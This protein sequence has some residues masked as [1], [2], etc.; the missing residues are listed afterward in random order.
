MGNFLRRNMGSDS[1]SEEWSDEKDFSG[2]EDDSSDGEESSD[3]S[4]D[5]DTFVRGYRQ[6]KNSGKSKAFHWS[7]RGP[8][9]PEHWGELKPAYALASNGSQQSPIDICELSDPKEVKVEMN[10]SDT[11]ANVLNNGHTIQVNYDAG[12]YI[13]VDGA[14]FELKQFHFHTPSEH[15]Q[16]GKHTAMEMHLVHQ[17]A[18]KQLAVVGVFIRMGEEN[19]VIKNVWDAMPPKPSQHKG[20]HEEPPQIVNAG[21]LN[22]EDILPQKRDLIQYDGSL[23]TPPCSEGVYWMMMKAPITFSSAQVKKFK[24]MF[25]FNNRPTQPLNERLVC[26]LHQ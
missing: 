19:Q 17:S 7:Y 15:T 13:S 12:S 1:D 9:G 24:K 3:E 8:T 4:S 23:T 22:I 21:S 26:P 6:G 14:K 16:K 20:G 18:T 10:Y 25:K 2:S 11:A 5:E